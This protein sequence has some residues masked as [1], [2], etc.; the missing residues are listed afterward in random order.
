MGGTVFLRGPLEDGLSNLRNFKQWQGR[1]GGVQTCLLCKSV[2]QSSCSYDA[3]PV[4]QLLT[5]AGGNG[6]SRRRPRREDWGSGEG[7]GKQEVISELN[8]ILAS[9][10]KEHLSPLSIGQ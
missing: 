10:K 3:F 6:Q 2:S 4:L 1:G 8:E 7:P 9:G 5:R